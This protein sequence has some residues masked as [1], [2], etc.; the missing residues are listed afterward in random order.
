LTQN[1]PGRD[2]PAVDSFPLAFGINYTFRHAARPVKVQI[3]IEVLLVESLDGLSMR[4]GDVPIAI[5]LSYDRSI[6]GSAK[7]LSLECRGRDLVCSIN[8]L[9]N[10][11]AT[12]IDE[13]TAVIGVKAPNPERKLHEHGFQNRH[14]PSFTDIGQLRRLPPIA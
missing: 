1:L 13:F 4:G 6:L 3:R 2:V 11:S 7:P 14:Q 9:F 10:S 5:V 8:S 12:V